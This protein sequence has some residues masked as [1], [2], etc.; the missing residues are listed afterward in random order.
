MTAKKLIIIGAGGHGKVVADCAE[1]MKCYQEVVFL[2]PRYQ[3]QEKQVQKQGL[4]QGI[5]H[6]HWPIVD[7]PDNFAEYQGAEVDFFVAIG[8]NLARKKVLNKLINSNVNI[9]K[10][11]HPRA[12]VSQ[13]AQLG[14]GTLVCANATINAFTKIGVGAIINTSASV[15]HDGVFGDF[16]HI[17][18]NNSI[19]GGVTVGEL[20]FIG[21]GSSIIQGI[22]IGENTT[23]GAG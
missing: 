3:Q 17:A 22:N 12:E 14:A 16:V 21:I 18:P 11:V 4:K 20:G 23:V 6:E 7:I 13:Y 9:A 8:E 2:D 15:D 10:L 19:A 5:K 1:M